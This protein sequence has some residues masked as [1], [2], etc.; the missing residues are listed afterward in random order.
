MHSVRAWVR[1][2]VCHFFK[3]GCVVS[4]WPFQCFMTLLLM[5]FHLMLFFSDLGP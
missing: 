2:C 1:E 5:S 4:A 3:K